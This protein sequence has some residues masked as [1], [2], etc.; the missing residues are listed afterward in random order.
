MSERVGKNDAHEIVLK[1]AKNDGK[2]RRFCKECANEKVIVRHVGELTL[3]PAPTKSAPTANS[4]SNYNDEAPLL[5]F[6]IRIWFAQ[7]RPEKINW[8]NFPKDFQIFSHCY[9]CN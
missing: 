1:Q 2:N 4:L 8:L 6:Q 3:P 5:L 9:H 7:F